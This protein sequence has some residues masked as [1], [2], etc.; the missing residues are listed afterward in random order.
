MED[1]LIESELV[2]PGARLGHTVVVKSLTGSTN[3]D[4]KALAEAGAGEGVAVIA[5]QQER[6]RGRKGRAW[7]S[8]A[9][10]NLLFSVVLRPQPELAPGLI[11]LA[12]GV[13]VAQA[14]EDVCGLFARIKWPNDVRVNGKKLAGILAEAGGGKGGD[15]VVLGIGLNVNAEAGDMAE[16]IRELASSLRIETG[17]RWPRAEVFRKVTAKLEESLALAERD[18][19]ALLEKWESLAEALGREVRAETPAGVIFGKAIGVGDDGALRLLET[20]SGKERRIVAGDVII[21]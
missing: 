6:G 16:E 11:T 19:S 8:P 10:K 1:R 18:P 17:R 15:Y 13:G 2:R 4:A 5:D 14:V 12:A 21:V 9:G 7:R 20:A 3:D